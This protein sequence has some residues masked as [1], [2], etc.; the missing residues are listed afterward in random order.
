MR[1]TLMA[2]VVI[3]TQGQERGEY[4]N[5]PFRPGGGGLYPD[6]LWF[7]PTFHVG[8]GSAEHPREACVT[9]VRLTTSAPRAYR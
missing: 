8:G 5:I 4:P 6:T 2:F 3:V 7:S 1:H 9:N